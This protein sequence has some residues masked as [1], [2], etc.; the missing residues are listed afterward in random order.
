MYTLGLQVDLGSGKAIGREGC[1]TVASTGGDDH[2]Q[3]RY[4]AIQHFGPTT[5]NMPCAKPGDDQPFVAQR[6]HGLQQRRIC[7]QAGFQQG[8][9]MF[10]AMR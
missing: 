7:V 8:N 5:G 4:E 2:R 1:R 9:A 10:G 3:G 6:G